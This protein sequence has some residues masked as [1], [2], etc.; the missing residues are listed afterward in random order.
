M[1]LVEISRFFLSFNS[2]MLACGQV[3]E[4][5][6]LREA[7]INCELFVMSGVPYHALDKAIE[8]DLH[9]PVY[10]I[11]SVLHISKISRNKNK[12]A[13][14]HIKIETGL[15]TA[16]VGGVVV[17]VCVCNVLMNEDLKEGIYIEKEQD[18]N[19]HNLLLYCI[20]T[21]F[22]IIQENNREKTFDFADLIH[23][24]PEIYLS[25]RNIKSFK[26]EIRIFNK[27]YKTK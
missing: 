7:G 21:L 5:A 13:K 10:N 18:K 19:N 6:E 23:N 9:I 3:V 25:K 15:K 17:F 16:A 11:E 22:E 2:D 20:D 27:K 26:R 4:A 8:L 14:V 24:M 1:G 12:K